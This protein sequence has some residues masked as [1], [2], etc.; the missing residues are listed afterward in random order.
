[1][2]SLGSTFGPRVIPT[3]WFLHLVVA[4]RN[5]AGVEGM[6]TAV[7]LGEDERDWPDHER[8]VVVVRS[9]TTQPSW[10]KADGTA[11]RI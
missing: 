4:G 10:Q 3:F 6:A 9:T 11:T 5:A 7:S 2:K 1:M 8:G